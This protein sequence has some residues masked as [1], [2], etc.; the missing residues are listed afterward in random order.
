VNAVVV[1]IKVSVVLLV[2]VAGFFYIKGGNYHPFVPETGAAD[3]LDPGVALPGADPARRDMG[4]VTPQG[5]DTSSGL[6]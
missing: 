1:A 5:A 3:R 4:A 2:I 6:G